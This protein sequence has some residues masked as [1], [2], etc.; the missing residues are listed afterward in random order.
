[1]NWGKRI[2]FLYLA[3]VAGIVLLVVKSHG[4]DVSLVRK[5]YYEQELAYSHRMV[6]L[7]NYYQLPHGIE[8]VQ[9][10]TKIDIAL[11]VGHWQVDSRTIFLY[12]P[13]NAK[14]DKMFEIEP[15][16]KGILHID[17]AVLEQGKYMIKID[18]VKDQ[19]AYAFEQSVIV[20]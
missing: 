19:K 3:F 7:Q 4:K 2:L 16:E 9:K 8:M 14:A 18:W 1:M 10:P 17:K 20:H 15:D 5:D 12:K 11:P 6:A 13:D